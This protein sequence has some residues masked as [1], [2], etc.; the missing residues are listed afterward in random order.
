PAPGGCIDIHG[1]L[2]AARL[3]IIYWR[4]YPDVP[5]TTSGSSPS[6]VPEAWPDGGAGCEAIT[7]G[8]V[9]PGAF[10]GRSAGAAAACAWVPSRAHAA[11]AGS[12]CSNARRIRRTRRRTGRTSRTWKSCLI[13]RDERE[14]AGRTCCPRCRRERMGWH[15]R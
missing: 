10:G 13:I 7:A 14:W 12:A 15:G 6:Q 9:D 4:P 5:A 3:V 11:W 8:G 1:T 2:L